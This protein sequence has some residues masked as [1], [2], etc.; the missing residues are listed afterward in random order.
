MVVTQKRSEDAADED[1]D[2]LAALLGGLGIAKKTCLTCHE[3]VQSSGRQYCD[4][5][6]KDLDRAGAVTSSTKITG[7]MRVLKE[8]LSKDKTNKVIIFSQFISFFKLLE[9]YIQKT[10]Y[11]FVQCELCRLHSSTVGQ[12]LTSLMI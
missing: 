5:C 10:G 1:V 2:D 4:Q 11:K 7:L 6:Q 3:K 9:P 8:E 12:R